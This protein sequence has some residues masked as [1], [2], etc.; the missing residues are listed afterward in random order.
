MIAYAR[1]VTDNG[2][3]IA[4]LYLALRGAA[5]VDPEARKLY[6]RG[7]ASDGSPC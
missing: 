5:E 1:F 7:K 4:P 6:L 2:S 3:R